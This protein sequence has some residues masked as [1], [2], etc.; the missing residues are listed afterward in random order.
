MGFA[1]GFV[2]RTENRGNIVRQYQARGHD[3][4]AGQSLQTPR[5][6]FSRQRDLRR[7]RFDLGLR[8]ARHRTQAQRQGGVVARDGDDAQRRRRPR[9]RHPAASARLGGFGS[10]CRTSPIRWSTAK[11]ASSASAPTTFKGDPMPRVRRRTHRGAQIQPDVQ[12][13]HGPGRGHRERGLPASRNRAGHFPEFRQHR[14]HAAGKAAVRSR[15]DRQIVPQR[16]H[17]RQLHLSHPRVRAD[18]DGVLRQAGRGRGGAMVRLL[19]RAAFR[20]VRE[21]RHAARASEAAPA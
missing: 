2:V 5:N 17:A 9:Q 10:C 11:A 18:G 3:G 20:L 16:N 6:R 7:T 14:R 19:G 4:K 13:L 8:P 1:R 12:D 21:L 15:A